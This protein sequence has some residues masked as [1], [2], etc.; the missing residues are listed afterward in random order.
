MLGHRKE[1]GLS[2]KEK[3]DRGERRRDRPSRFDRSGGRS[4]PRDEKMGLVERLRNLASGGEMGQRDRYDRDRDR[5]DRDRDRDRDRG[6]VGH[7]RED[8]VHD[9]DRDRDDARGR[10]DS[11]YMSLSLSIC[12]YPIMS[13]KLTIKIW[14]L[15]FCL[16]FANHQ[17]FFLKVVSDR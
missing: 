5:R 3:D 4:P 15:S 12:F 17:V 1:N 16:C 11:K 9:R 6:R 2:S 14:F 7:D 10:D 8:R 13:A